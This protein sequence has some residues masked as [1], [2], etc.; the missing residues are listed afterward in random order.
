MHRPEVIVFGD[1]S[2]CALCK[3]LCKNIGMHNM[4]A[5]EIL[6]A[7][8][9]R[10]MLEAGNPSSGPAVDRTAKSLGL[11]LGRTTVARYTHADGNPSLDHIEALAKVFGVQAWQLLHPEMGKG[12]EERTR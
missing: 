6:S 4:R 2:N 7:N 11:R 5:A 12:L 3:H 1:T 9:R 10:L 8:L